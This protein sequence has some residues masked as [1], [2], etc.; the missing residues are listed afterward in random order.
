VTPGAGDWNGLGQPDELMA[1]GKLEVEITA[2]KYVWMGYN[3]RGKHTEPRWVC[4]YTLHFDNDVDKEL[5]TQVWEEHTTLFDNA[6]W[7][8]D[9]HAMNERMEFDPPIEVRLSKNGI[10]KLTDVMDNPAH[11]RTK[12]AELIPPGRNEGNEIPY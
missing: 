2:A 12:Q 7:K 4:W 6:G 8:F 5:S 9:W 10:W 11:L 1:D 3:Q